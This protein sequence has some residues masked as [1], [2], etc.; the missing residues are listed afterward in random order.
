MVLSTVAAWVLTGGIVVSGATWVGY[1]ALA[2]FESRPAALRTPVVLGA[3]GL[4][5]H[6]W[7]YGALGYE[8][9]LLDSGALLYLSVALLVATLPVLAGVGIRGGD[10]GGGE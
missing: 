5:G 4:V 7:L 3:S 6:Y 9:F 1:L 8:G 10:D 2:G